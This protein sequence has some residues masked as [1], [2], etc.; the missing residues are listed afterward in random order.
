MNAFLAEHSQDLRG[1]IIIEL[2]GMGAGELSFVER[3]GAY[4]TVFSRRA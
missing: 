4:K 1:A 2:E 3:E